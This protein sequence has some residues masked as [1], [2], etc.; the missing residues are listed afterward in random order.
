MI[1]MSETLPAGTTD[2]V[3]WMNANLD[4]LSAALNR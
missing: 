1:Q 2:W 3:Q 4:E